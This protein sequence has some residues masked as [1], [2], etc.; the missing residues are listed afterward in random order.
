MK[1]CTVCHDAGRIVTELRTKEGWDDTIDKMAARGAMAS[2]EEFK[3]I[4]NYLAKNFGKG[5]SARKQPIKIRPKPQSGIVRIA[6]PVFW[7]ACD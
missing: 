4:V 7:P 5:Q 1:V 3:A 6:M 2:D